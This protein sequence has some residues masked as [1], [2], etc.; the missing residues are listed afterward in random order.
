MINDMKFYGFMH[1][2]ILI[3]LILFIGTGPGYIYIGWLYS[4]FH[5]ELLWYIALLC[6]C[7]WGYVL[8]KQ[9]LRKKMSLAEKDR[10]LARLK[11]FLYIAFSMWSVMFV[12]YTSKDILELHY[13]AIATQ[14]GSSVVAAT[15]LASQRRLAILTVV[16]LMLPL[17]FYFLIINE[18]YSY[19]LA[20]FSVVLA[21]VLLHSSNNT[22]N[23]LVKSRYQSY[24]DYL[25]KLGNRR[26]FIEMLD[27]AIA[28]QRRTQKYHYLLLVDLDHFKIIN[29]T[30]GHDIGDK[31]LCE[32]ANRMKNL[33][34]V[35]NKAKVSRLGGD[36]FCLLSP[37]YDSIQECLEY[38]NSFAQELLE[39]IKESYVIGE[40]H[41]YISASIGIS[42]LDKPDMQANRFIKE[43][44]IAMYE[45]KNQGRDGL[46]I[47]NDKVAQHIQRKLEIERLLH[48]AIESKEIYLHY[49]PQL[50]IK[51]EII[52][53]E[54]LARWESLSLGNVRPDHFIAIA[55]QT[56]IIIELGHY[57]LE[58]SFKTLKEW[59]QKGVKL[60]HFSINISMRQMFHSSF[61]EDV[62]ALSEKHL[63]AGLIKKLVFEI[64]E[65]SVAEDIHILI[66][67][68]NKLKEYGI[69]FSMDDFGTGYS[70][71]SYLRQLPI[72]ELKIDKSF[73]AKIASSKQ[74][75]TMI[76][77][78]INIAQNLE[79][80]I[81]AEGVEDRLEV[82][83]LAEE[84]CDI[85]Q[86]YFFYKPMSKE[87]FELLKLGA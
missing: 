27:D 2:Q 74:D 78:I 12:I 9:Y 5:I 83:Y 85:F 69:R 60:E 32:V 82:D 15:V 13:I 84:E 22:F 7:A 80:R 52:G 23:Y 71:L 75:R 44:D 79:L 46:I 49:Q 8:H 35:N 57:I 45:A 31:L 56:G 39:A 6:V 40:H 38:G 16:S 37:E 53:C 64:T 67:N 25:T 11:I 48:F 47:F 36:E 61:V 42:I 43:A 70:S 59:D 30:L 87:S 33:A 4:S 72:S 29:D 86:G 54:V 63:E 20:F 3:L 55:E 14:L 19:L 81:V 76:K 62:I 77:T 73:V 10:W 66:M 51:E 65:S 34:E 17:T 68:M 21:W 18:Y 1:K 58:E 41:L 24:H 28:I 50:N 26:Y